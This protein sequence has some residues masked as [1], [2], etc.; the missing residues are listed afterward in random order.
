MTLKQVGIQ[1]ALPP[2]L[3]SLNT[4]WTQQQQQQHQAEGVSVMLLVL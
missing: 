3:P 1:L 4:A 2:P